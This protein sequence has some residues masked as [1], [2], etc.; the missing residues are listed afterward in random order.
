LKFLKRIHLV[1]AIYLRLWLLTTYDID[2]RKNNDPD[3]I[4]E[5]PVPRDHLERVRDAVSS[6]D[7][8]GSRQDQPQQRQA[9]YYVSGVQANSE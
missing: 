2:D 4:H 1:K 6:G 8:A 7:L 9:H 3:G 5:M